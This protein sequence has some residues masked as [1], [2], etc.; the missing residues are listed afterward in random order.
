M[1]ALRLR[2]LLAAGAIVLGGIAIMLI[3]KGVGD[4]PVLKGGVVC[5]LGV[6]L[7]VTGLLRPE[8]SPDPEPRPRLFQPE[9]GETD[10]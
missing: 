1:S 2:F 6:I 10:D 7:A 9:G 4:R 5:V 8:A 3:Q